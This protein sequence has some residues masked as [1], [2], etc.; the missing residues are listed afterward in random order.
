MKELSQSDKDK[1]F[2]DLLIGGIAITCTDLSGIRRIDPMS[3]ELRDAMYNELHSDSK[4]R[5][6][7]LTKEQIKAKYPNWDKWMLDAIAPID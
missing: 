1:L 7:R 5:T 2:E 3:D 4:L 6:E